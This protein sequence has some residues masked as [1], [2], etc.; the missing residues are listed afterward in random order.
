MDFDMLD[1]VSQADSTTYLMA[2]QVR[3]VDSDAREI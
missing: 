2:N 1:A 3:A